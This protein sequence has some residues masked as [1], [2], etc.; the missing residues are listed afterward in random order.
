MPVEAF[1]AAESAVR[2]A[3]DEELSFAAAHRILHGIAHRAWT[4]LDRMSAA[5]SAQAE[6]VDIR[7]AGLLHSREPERPWIPS[8]T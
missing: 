8:Q 6:V 5:A 3:I 4:K 2:E 1:E 7:S